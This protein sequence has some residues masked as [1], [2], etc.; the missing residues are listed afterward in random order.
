MLSDSVRETLSF[1]ADLRLPST[2][3]RQA[4]DELVQSLIVELGLEGCTETRIGDPG[5]GE[6]GQGGTRGISG[7]ERR[8]LSTAIQL[9]TNPSLLL[10]DEVTSGMLE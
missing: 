5:G 3:P 2:L 10:C 9:L 6:A 1:T 7:G 4:K 8:R